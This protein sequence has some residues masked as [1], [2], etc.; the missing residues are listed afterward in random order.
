MLI[1]EGPLH[2]QLHDFL[3]ANAIPHT[4]TGY[5]PSAWKAL[6]AMDVFALPSLSEGM[7]IVLLEAAQARIPIIA[8]NTGGIPELLKDHAEALLL[9]PADPIA[10]AE[11]CRRIL[12]DNKFAESLTENAWQK[13]SLFTLEK[14]AKETVDFY[15]E[16]ISSRTFKFLP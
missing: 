4:I 13:A 16:I 15:A 8:S 6:P 3:T 2:C 5:F 1:G 10:L 12:N 11:A 7:G 9:P 14:M